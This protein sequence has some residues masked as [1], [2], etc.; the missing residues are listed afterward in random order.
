[1]QKKCN[2]VDISIIVYRFIN[3]ITQNQRF[4]TLQNQVSNDGRERRP[5]RDAKSLL[6]NPVIKMEESGFQDKFY[7]KDEFIKRKVSVCLYVWPFFFN[8]FDHQVEWNTSEEG[9]YIEG[10]QT[11]LLF[12]TIYSIYI[13]DFFEFS[14]DKY[15]K[16]R[17]VLYNIIY[18]YK[19]SLYI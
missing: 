18:K 9:S 6:V 17:L 1:V 13:Q 15:I 19:L 12:F 4:E 14:I 3:K 8:G 11:I 5:H 16:V 2:V 7:G 10:S